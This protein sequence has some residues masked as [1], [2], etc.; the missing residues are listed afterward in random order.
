MSLDLSAAAILPE[1]HRQAT[2]VGRVWLPGKPGGPTVVTLREDKLIDL[3]KVAATVSDVINAEDPVAL[4]RNCTGSEIGQIDAVLANSLHSARD[5]ELAYLL[6]PIDLQ[7]IKAC[8]V[9]FVESLLERVIEEGAKGDPAAAQEIRQNIGAQIGADL[10]NIVPGSEQALALKAVLVEQGLWSPY[11]EV[12]IGPDAEVFTKAQPMSAVGTGAEVGLHRKSNWS[13][14]EPELVL[15]INAGGQIIGVT[16]GNDVNLRDIEGRSALLLGS[17]KD[18]NGSA[19]VGP[20]LRLFD[21]AFTID[22]A[23]TMDISLRVEGDDGFVLDGRSSMSQIA[24]D[25][26]DLARQTIGPSHQYPDGL[27]LYTGTLFAPTQDRGAAGQGFTHKI[28]D[29]VM[30][31]TPK[32]GCLANRVNHCD[33]ITPWT[34]G[35]GALMRNLFERGI[36]R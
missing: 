24:R 34:F 21:D 19:A 33:K 15:V 20:F 13:N 17:A 27:V 18:N 10:A 35:A 26:T 32:L 23:R 6:T 16:L 8:G 5:S 28:G 12:G 22:E 25:I 4:I 9:T 7:A 1:D 3:S 14:P 2:L 36:L 31:H 11:L 29:R 30:I